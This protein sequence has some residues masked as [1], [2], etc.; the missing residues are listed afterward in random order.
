[1]IERDVVICCF[2]NRISRRPN[3]KAFFV[4]ISDLGDG[5]AWYALIL[6]L[7]LVYGPTGLTTSFDMVRVGVVNLLLYKIIKTT[8]WPAAAERSQY[9]HNRHNGPLDQYSFPSGHTMHAVA[10]SIIAMGIIRN[11]LWCSVFIIQRT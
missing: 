8:H 5:G 2:L 10:F 4:S 11:W 6:L 1:M 7:P 9:E 3:V